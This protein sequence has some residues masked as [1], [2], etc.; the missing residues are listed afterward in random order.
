MR[1]SFL[2]AGLLLLFGA[3]VLSVYSL[4][5]FTDIQEKE[6]LAI[7][8]FF[9]HHILWLRI[10]ALALIAYPVYYIIRYKRV[11][12]KLLLLPVLAG[13]AM[14]YYYF[15]VYTAPKEVYQPV[16]VKTFAP[17]NQNRINNN[18]LV[19][20]VMINGVAKAYPVQIISYH[21]Q[22]ADSVGGTPVIITYCSL[23]RSARVYS[24]VV[25]GKPDDFVLMGLNK[26]NSVFEDRATKSWWQQETG[27]AIAG[28]MKGKK[29]EEIPSQQV[30]LSG[31]LKEY[32]DALVMQ[33]DSNY[34]AAYGLAD[35]DRAYFRSKYMGSNAADY[36][37]KSLVVGVLYNGN[38]KAYDWDVLTNTRFIEDS[39]P[40]APL[41]LT[42]ETD[43]TSFHA[44]ERDVKGQVLQFE[45]IVNT[46]EI[47]DINTQSTWDMQGVCIGGALQGTKLKALPSY[48]ETW[49]SWSGFHPKT[50]MYKGFKTTSSLI[51]F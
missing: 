22:V 50:E 47:K 40:G 32:P 17:K 33:P 36:K 14:V 41:L 31:W 3:E 26:F 48:L 23:C 7:T 34:L 38:A 39:L 15:N 1:S 13:Y 12:Q 37:A 43:N 18:K 24:S 49:K 16:Q 6:V 46:S 9:H 10:L 11:W 30:T 35:D 42:L 29:L 19:I 20:G 21:H 5:P 28:P 45:R 8:Y 51:H 2:V 4:L 27:I 44:W 25:E